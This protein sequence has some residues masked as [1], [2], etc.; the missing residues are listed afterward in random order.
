MFVH[1]LPPDAQQLLKKLGQVPEVQP[2][3]LAGG[4][5]VALHLG[6]RVSVDLDFFTFQDDYESGPLIQGLQRI[7]HLDIRQQSRGTLNGFLAGVRISFFA[8]PYP[9]LMGTL[10][11][12]G[13]Q[14]A[15][16]LD[17]A[18]MKLL[19]IGQRGTRRDFIDLYF[20]CHQGFRLDDLLRRI[21]KKYTEL[22][23][24]SYHLLRALVYFEDAERDEPPPMLVPFDWNQAKRFFEYQVRRLVQEL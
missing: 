20:I 1:T 16:L 14:I 4:S 8:L 24:P 7:G 3:Y 12:D 18:L 5:A 11:L 17:L 10:E 13:I 9:L 21:P 19:A 15:D 23:Y 6:H 22:S 2:F